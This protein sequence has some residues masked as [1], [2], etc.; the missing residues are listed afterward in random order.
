MKCVICKTGE[1]KPGL[2]TVTLL[3]G[4]TTVLIKGTPAEVCENCGEYYLGEVVAHKVYA[5]AEAA[6]Q[7][8]AEVEILRYAA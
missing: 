2:V 6:V 3:R 4:D 1:I 5:Q 8:R 7:R